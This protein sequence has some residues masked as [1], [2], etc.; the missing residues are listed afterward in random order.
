MK[1][2][3]SLAL[4]FT[5]TGA[6]MQQANAVTPFTKHVVGS[7][8]AGAVVSLGFLWTQYAYN[9]EDETEATFKGFGEF[10]MTTR[11]ATEAF[12]IF[13]VVG[14]GTLAVLERKAIKERYKAYIRALKPLTTDRKLL[15][16]MRHD[17]QDLCEIYDD[18][19]EIKSRGCEIVYK[20]PS[21]ENLQE[22]ITIAQERDPSVSPEN[23]TQIRTTIG[24]IKGKKKAAITT[25]AHSHGLNCHFSDCEEL[26]CCNDSQ[27]VQQWRHQSNAPAMY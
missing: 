20:A 2:M 25:F 14:G 12:A 23:I 3:L 1:K 11:H 10:L 9:L 16:S 15:N 21:A 22:A 19:F 7:V 17:Y 18:F 13:A 5:L 26:H 8:V 24:N 6:G 4:C 27:Q